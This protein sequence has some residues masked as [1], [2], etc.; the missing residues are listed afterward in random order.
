MRLLHKTTE[1]T[2]VFD[3]RKSPK[4]FLRLSSSKTKTHSHSLCS[5]RGYLTT[6]TFKPNG[7]ELHKTAVT[8]CEHA[9]QVANVHGTLRCS[10]LAL[11]SAEHT[12]AKYVSVQYVASFFLRYL[13]CWLYCI[14]RHVNIY[15]LLVF[16]ANL[17]LKNSTIFRLIGQ[18]TSAVC[19]IFCPLFFGRLSLPL[20]HHLKFFFIFPSVCMKQFCIC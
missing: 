12:A 6:P 18:E 13:D 7:S 16:M 20:G 4:S 8:H 10:D 2:K 5:H 3:V 14:L 17:W 1:Y 9:M 19:R 11:M 15:F